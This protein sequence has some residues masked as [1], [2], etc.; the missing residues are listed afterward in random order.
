MRPSHII[1]ALRITTNPADYCASSA[2]LQNAWAT[3]KAE[4]GQAVDHDRIGPPAYR[5]EADAE[6]PETTELGRDLE[7]RSGRV[8]ERVI[9][10]SAQILTGATA[11]ETDGAA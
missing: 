9:Q 6:Q 10:R 11:A 5:I 2:V 8:K 3:L 4:R 7:I 1:T